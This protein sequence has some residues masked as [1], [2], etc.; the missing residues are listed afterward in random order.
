MDSNASA[1][2]PFARSIASASLKPGAAVLFVVVLAV[3]VVKAVMEL[4]SATHMHLSCCRLY[5]LAFIEDTCGNLFIT[6][7][8]FNDWCCKYIPWVTYAA[9]CAPVGNTH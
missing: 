9:V 3:V 8:C 7:S 5:Q 2:P 4:P 1:S 6:N